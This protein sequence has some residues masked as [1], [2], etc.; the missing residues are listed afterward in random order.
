MSC[1]SILFTYI[2]SP[3]YTFFCECH[4]VLPVSMISS[5][6]LLPLTMILHTLPSPPTP[7]HPPPSPPP[8]YSLSPQSLSSNQQEEDR[9]VNAEAEYLKTKMALP[10][11]NAKERRECLIRM[12]YCEMLGHNM[13]H[14][15]IHAVK[16]LQS[17]NIM[18]KRVGEWN[19]CCHGNGREVA[20]MEMMKT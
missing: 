8:P 16:F 13:S 10:E 12:V 20:G 18:D 4:F 15:Y 6:L 19:T 14:C 1:K 9:I 7:F 17:N 3:M 5:E 2:N 11:L